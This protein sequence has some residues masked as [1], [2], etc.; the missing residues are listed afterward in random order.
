MDP[1]NTSRSDRWLELA[2]SQFLALL[3]LAGCVWWV[4]HDLAF[5]IGTSRITAVDAWAQGRNSVLPARVAGFALA[6]LG[7]HVA[8]GLLAWGLA[9]LTRAAM[10]FRA[11]PGAPALITVWMLLI[12]LLVLATNTAWYP[13]SRFAREE[14]WLSGEWQGLRPLPVMLVSV[15]VVIIVLAML[16]LRRAR[17]RKRSWLRGLAVPAVLVA[18]VVWLPQPKVARSQANTATTDLN[19]VIL[20]VDSLRNDLSEASDGRQLTPHIDAFLNGAHRFRDAVTPLARTYPAW[21]SILTGR[22]P[23]TTNARFNLM[24]RAL[25]HEGDTLAETLHTRG[26]RSVF[27]TDEMRFANFDESF[28]FDELITPPIGASDFLLGT[29]GDLPLV[30]VL[31]G[32]WIGGWLFPSNHANRAAY[33]TYEPA[34]FLSRL[35]RELDLTGPS[36]LAIHLT[37]SHWPYS[38]A[39]QPLPTTPQEYRPAYRL[40]IEEVDRQ[41]QDVLQLLKRKGVLDNAI[42]V[43]LSDHGDALGFPSDSMLR[44]TGTSREIWDSLWG[45]GTSVL[46]PHQYGVLLA[47]RA[48]GR[49]RLPGNPAVHDWPVALEDVRPTLEELVAGEAPQHVDGISLVPYLAGTA[50]AVEFESRVRFTETCFNTVMMM[51]GEI[52][53][54]GLVSEAAIFYQMVPDTGWV[55]LRPDRLGEIM[56]K[57]QRAAISQDSLLAAIPSWNDDTVSYLFSSRQSPLPRRLQGRP[58]PATEPEAARLWE[59][60][61]AR[62]PGEL[63]AHFNL[64]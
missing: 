40:A 22:H 33:V 15:A 55:Q 13:A 27:A 1:S 39:G 28:G 14:S 37:L 29:V 34:H 49:A 20:G 26:Y 25:V 21:V 43:V 2:L 7:T 41:F 62:F 64:P 53:P 45:H 30:N 23:V 63:P 50:P 32:T 48:F 18:A 60:L 16:A 42:V 35:D 52:N 8:L 44:K 5:V 12:V 6:V 36:F 24:P 17:L 9:R 59:A 56:A 61:H 3:F 57:K 51:A 47:M 38:W 46:S 19:I 54:S 11:M 58:D 10:R 31:A 4:Y